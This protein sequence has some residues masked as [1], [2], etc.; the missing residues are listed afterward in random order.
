ML[1]SKI[2]SVIAATIIVLSINQAIASSDAPEIQSV[3]DSSNPKGA[4]ALKPASAGKTITSPK[5]YSIAT[6]L[7]GVATGIIVGTPICMVRKPL[8]EDKYAVADLTGNS[9]NGRA[10]VPTAALWA[11]F[12][13]AQGILEAPFWAV[14]NSL[15]NYKKPFSKNQFSLVNPDASVKK[16]EEKEKLDPIPYNAR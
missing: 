11:P 14:N 6:K 9:H 13:A 15:V 8:D 2:H 4:V 16:E 5:H 7:L 3:A 10:V 12:A 1:N